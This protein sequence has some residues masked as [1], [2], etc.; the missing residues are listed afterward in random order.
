MLESQGIKVK[1]F[2]PLHESI[3]IREGFYAECF[4]SFE[5]PWK[6]RIESLKNYYGESV[7][8]YFAFMTHYNSWLLY[9]AALRYHIDN[10]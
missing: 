8:F 10:P 9:F 7:G 6:A 2:F 1:A 3:A 4:P 5:W